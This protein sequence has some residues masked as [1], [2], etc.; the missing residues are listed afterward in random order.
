MGA[1]DHRLAVDE[2]GAVGDAEHRAR[3]DPNQ[4][5]EHFVPPTRHCALKPHAL[6]TL[7]ATAGSAFA[8]GRG[9]SPDNWPAAC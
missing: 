8:M 5:P 9:T 4:D 2:C 7:H 1:V 3:A 6:W